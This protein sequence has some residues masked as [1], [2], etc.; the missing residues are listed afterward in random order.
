MPAGRTRACRGPP[1][2]QYPAG[3]GGG[4]PGWRLLRNKA[5][6]TTAVLWAKGTIGTIEPRHSPV[7]GVPTLADGQHGR[8]WGCWCCGGENEACGEH[9]GQ[10]QRVALSSRVGRRLRRW[11]ANSSVT[12]A[13]L[14]QSSGAACPPPPHGTWLGLLFGVRGRCAGHVC[15]TRRPG[16]EMAHL[17]G[18]CH[19][20]SSSGP[21][22]RQRVATGRGKARC[23]SC[24]GERRAPWMG[25][26]PTRGPA[27]PAPLPTH[28]ALGFNPTR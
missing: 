18:L 26:G 15:S 27:R 8:L 28:H 5:T 13:P 23:C 9:C 2:P 16:R 21:A 7:A 3:N 6:K 22:C 10:I 1:A 25:N 12:P 14:K 17:T 11:I 4:G 19:A 20:W 24:L